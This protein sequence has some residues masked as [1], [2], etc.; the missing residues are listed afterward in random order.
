MVMIPSEGVLTASQNLPYLQCADDL[1]QVDVPG[2]VTIDPVAAASLTVH[3]LDK[4]RTVRWSTPEVVR[5]RDGHSQ[6]S[7]SG[8]TTAHC[9]TNSMGHLSARIQKHGA[10]HGVVLVE[11]LAECTENG[12]PVCGVGPSTTSICFDYK[13]SSTVLCNYN[14]RGAA[15]KHTILSVETMVMLIMASGSYALTDSNSGLIPVTATSRFRLKEHQ[16]CGATD[17]CISS[18]CSVESTVRLQTPFPVCS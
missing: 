18:T 13:H 2:G 5:S 11:A 15:Y 10:V 16:I 8:H 1:P 9:H 3:Q 14:F 17:A 6:N 7:Y 4:L 12:V